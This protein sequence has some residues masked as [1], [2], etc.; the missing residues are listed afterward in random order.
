[1][2]RGKPINRYDSFNGLRLVMYCGYYDKFKIVPIP[3]GGNE[4]VSRK[5][6]LVLVVS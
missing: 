3:E 1:M 2:T 6:N 4:L 5:D